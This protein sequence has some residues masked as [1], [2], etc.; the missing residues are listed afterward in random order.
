MGKGTVGNGLHARCTDETPTCSPLT[1]PLP[2][3]KLLAE[4]REWETL[5]RMADFQPARMAALCSISLRHL[6][7]LCSARFQKTPSQWARELQC[8]LA[9]ELISCGYSTKAVAAELKFAN[10]SHFCREFKKV[11]GASS[12]VFSPRCQLAP[13]DNSEAK[14]LTMCVLS[15]PGEK[16]K[17]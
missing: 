17:A 2:V 4:N 14:D 10:E 8:R 7:R 1:T 3:S 6:E 13:V 5:A 15:L 12:K 11:Y 9:R 16:T